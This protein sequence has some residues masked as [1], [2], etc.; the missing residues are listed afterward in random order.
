ME[1]TSLRKIYYISPDK[2]DSIYNNRFNSCTTKHFS[3]DT[4]ATINNRFKE[5]PE[6][7]YFVDKGEKPY[8]YRLNMGILL[9]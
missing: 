9:E 1:Y 8:H 3:I 6:S 2:H 7:H 5:I 4:R